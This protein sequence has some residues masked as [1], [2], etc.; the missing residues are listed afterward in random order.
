MK[1]STLT[2]MFVAL[3]V[4]MAYCH[5]GSRIPVSFMMPVPQNPHATALDTCV[6]LCGDLEDFS[7]VRCDAQRELLMD[8]MLG[9][10]VRL[11]TALLGHEAAGDKGEAIAQEDQDF[12]VLALSRVAERFALYVAPTADPLTQEAYTTLD[13]QVKRLRGNMK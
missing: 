3:S 11:Y 1:F 4:C 5:Q 9:K 2:T 12:L 10:M 6:Q 13:H 7:C 8:A